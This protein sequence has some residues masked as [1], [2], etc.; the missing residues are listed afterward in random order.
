MRPP[1]RSVSKPSGRRTRE[2]VKT[3]VAASR[4]N[5]VSLSCSSSLMGTPNTANIIHTIKQTVKA[6]VLMPSTKPCLIRG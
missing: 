4:P 6:S 1:K 3:G 2:P 5:W